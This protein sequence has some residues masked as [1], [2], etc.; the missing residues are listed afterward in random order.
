MS[1]LHK[2]DS[3][4]DLILKSAKTQR[5][6]EKINKME[7]NLAYSVK[8]TP[9]L[10]TKKEEYAKAVTEN[11]DFD[12]AF[13]HT[14]DMTL[15]YG[16]PKDKKTVKE[17]KEK[18][19]SGDLEYDDISTLDRL[20]KTS[21]R[22]LF[23]KPPNADLSETIYATI[24]VSLVI[25]GTIVLRCI[26]NANNEHLLPLL[27]IINI[28]ATAYTI[29]IYPIEV[30]RNVKKWL[31]SN[32]VQPI[33][34]D[35]IMGRIRTKIWVLISVTFIFLI[36]SL[37]ICHFVFSILSIANDVISILAFGFSV[38][39]KNIIELLTVFYQTKIINNEA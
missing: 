10:K 24:I 37:L 7:D 25:L 17:L 9:L 38:L 35:R 16:S 15:K 6:K 13:T 39:Q 29:F 36:I 12:S 34:C 31:L 28:V 32:N 18:H 33:V 22:H 8:D 23:S 19:K 21:Y 3:F 14:Y 27:V 11:P 30:T 1:N 4:S 2:S 26:Y 20:T 5:K